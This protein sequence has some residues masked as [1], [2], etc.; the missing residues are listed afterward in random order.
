[1]PYN[2]FWIYYHQLKWSSYIFLH[3]WAFQWFYIFQI[4]IK[5]IF[6][7]FDPIKIAPIDSEVADNMFL[8]IIFEEDVFFNHHWI[9][10]QGDKSLF[11]NLLYQWIVYSFL[12]LCPLLREISD[13][14]NE[15]SIRDK[16]YDFGIIHLNKF[17]QLDY[18]VMDN[19]DYCLKSSD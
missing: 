15:F 6:N 16:E 2:K 11:I 12:M 14:V 18:Y 13:H 5:K 17:F 19:E 4:P 9:L 8:T 10:V 1:M 7:P 3:F